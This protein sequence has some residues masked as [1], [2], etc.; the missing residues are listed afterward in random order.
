L[1]KAELRQ[2]G[3]TET[4]RELVQDCGADASNT[5]EGQTQSGQQLLVATRRLCGRWCRSAA[6]MPAM[7]TRVQLL[8]QGDTDVMVA[9]SS[10]TPLDCDL[11]VGN[12]A[13]SRM[14]AERLCQR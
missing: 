14:L 12:E 9:H 10:L 8:V 7:Q 5:N 2:S 11:Y 4:V 6:Q 3:Q 1:S 13:L